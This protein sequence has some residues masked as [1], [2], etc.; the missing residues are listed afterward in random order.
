MIIVNINPLLSLFFLYSILFNTNKV[1]NAKN[2]IGF[3]ISKDITFSSPS[4]AN[5]IVTIDNI[6]FANNN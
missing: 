6:I 3:T 1:A 4:N 2:I 5:N